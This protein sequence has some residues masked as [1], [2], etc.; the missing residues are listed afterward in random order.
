MKRFLSLLLAVSFV[1]VAMPLPA[2]AEETGD[3]TVENDISVEGANDFGE[4]L[5]DSINEAEAEEQ[6]TETVGYNVTDLVI[7]GATAT[8]T[9]ETLEDANL[10][11]ALYTEDGVQM[12][13]SGSTEVTPEATTATVAIEGELPQYFL[14][15]AFLMDDYDFSPLCSEYTTPLYTQEMQE[16]LASTADDYDP[17]RVLALDDTRETN[18]AVYAETTMRIPVT[19]GVNT[20]TDNGDGSYTITSA[21]ESFTALQPGDVFSYEYTDGEMLIAKVADIAVDGT[22]VTITEDEDIEMSD[23]F[24]QVK[25][26]ADATTQ[27]V[28]YS[29]EGADPDV[30]YLGT[31]SAQTRSLTT[32]NAR[33]NSDIELEFKLNE[34]KYE[35]D[36]GENVTITGLV[37]LKMDFNLDYYITLSQF[38]VEFTD[39]VEIE[40][41]VE[42]K[43]K[44]ETDYALGYFKVSPIPGVNIDFTPS[45]VVKTTGTINTSV[46]MGMTLGFSYQSKSGFTNLCSA[47]D[48]E[49]LDCD[50]EG[51]LFLGLDFKPGISIISKSVLS[52]EVALEAGAETKASMIGEDFSNEKNEKH[53]CKKCVDG[54]VGFVLKI[55]PKF[56]FLKKI[57]LK[58]TAFTQKGKIMDFY[59]S[60][61]QDS[62]GVGTCPF[63]EF[64]VTVTAYDQNY[65]A[66]KGVTLTVSNKVATT[67]D[68]GVATFWLRSGDYII[69]A[70][71]PDGYGYSQKFAVSGPYTIWFPYSASE[72]NGTGI[73]GTVDSAEISEKGYKI[74]SGNCGTAA[75]WCF[76]S[77]GELEIS[78]SG[79]VVTTDNAGRPDVPWQNYKSQIKTVNVQEGITSL[80]KGSFYQCAALY[81]VRLPSTLK[82]I[83]SGCFDRCSNLTQISIPDNVTDIGIM[84]FA[85]TGLKEIRVPAGVTVLKDSVFSLS[86]NLTVVELPDTIVEIEEGALAG[87]GIRQIS[88]PTQ[89]KKIGILVFAECYNLTEVT[90]PEN[91]CYMEPYIFKDCTQLKTI[92][93]T[94]NA[95]QLGDT[96]YGGNSF[97]APENITPVVY[98]P[99]NNPTWTESVR[100]EMAPSLVWVAYTTGSAGVAAQRF[101]TAISSPE[102]ATAE[103]AVSEKEEKS[104]GAKWERETLREQLDE[105]R[106]EMGMEETITTPSTLAAVGGE[107]GTTETGGKTASFT[108][109]K[110]GGSYVL[111]ALA[112]VEAE[113]PLAADNLLY[114]T[115]GSADETGNLQFTY[116]PRMAMGTSYVVACGPSTKD[117]AD[118]EITVPV[119]Y[120]NGAVQTVR[121]TVVYDGE[122]LTEGVDYVLAGQVSATE[123]GDYQCTLRGIYNYTGTVTINYTL[124]DRLQEITSDTYE[125]ADG[126]LYLSAETTANTLLNGLV[127]TDIGIA[128]ADGAALTGTALVGTGAALAQGGQEAELTVVF[129][130]DLTG[131]GKISSSDMLEMQRAI[132]GISKL[133]GV[134]LKA[135]TPRSGDSEKPQTTDMLQMR[136][137]LLGIKA[138][139]LD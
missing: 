22:T 43:G 6:E 124:S 41:G 13:A 131:D 42:V 96:E 16:L 79:T 9:Y 59:Y 38:Y 3:A 123:P 2:R 68:N 89:L 26:E 51:T 33:A 119:M 120:A 32:M 134:R 105:K 139:M 104:D 76:W 112:N 11:V 99:Q 7:D 108:G 102:T 88:L 111:L 101:S 8:V 133:E 136:R 61:D 65:Q 50:I 132:L 85:E 5:S 58:I 95:P 94:G 37:G 47:P 60:V 125:I 55:E 77:N 63:R 117:L 114:I 113:K 46:Q 67:N 118:A 21:D 29:Q 28:N 73:L 84:A 57:E 25:I 20:L 40:G 138:T 14:A 128:A 107:Y 86:G 27:D 129:Y 49:V 75:Q 91:L 126:L 90:F 4:L 127:G 135:A 72:N 34:R 110:P 103:T 56:V 116:I 36:E 39:K 109:L 82:T 70:D 69:A 35:N 87:T 83:G 1:A 78:G 15:K 100:N 71:W 24:S 66:T 17:E 64:L 98:Y 93:F 45:F 137:V 80:G 48:I 44:L 10:V 122:T 74:A 92:R 62:F 54:S 106:R 97:F 31:G 130:G 121:P 81:N 19:E 23:V 30:E 52:L 115:Q 12:L 18:F 53:L